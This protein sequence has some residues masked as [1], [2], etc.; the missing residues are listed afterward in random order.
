[1]NDTHLELE[2]LIAEATG[3]PVDDRTREHLARCEH[4]RLEVNRW[5]LVADGVL[6]L[7]AA[8]P[9]VAPPARPRH[10]RLRVLAGP[11]RPAMLAVGSVAAAFVLLVAIGAAAGLVHVSLGGGSG[12]GTE[13]TLTAVSG[14]STPV[15]MAS[16]TVERV[17][18]TSVVITTASGQPVT[19]T[20][21]AST[22][23]IVAGA[24]LSDITDGASVMVLGPTS[25]GTVAAVSVE[26][27]PVPGSKVT[28][29]S[30]W[31]AVQ[32]TVTDA[33]T[34]DFTVVTSGGTR[35]AVTTSGDTFVV[36]M[37]ASLSQLHPGIPTAA[38]GTAGPD[39][40]LAAQGIVQETPGSMQVHTSTKIRGCPST[41]LDDALAAALKSGS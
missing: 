9:E 30:G 41:T 2:D 27:G 4:C 6:D 13:T 39:N 37:K 14:C 35:V 28:P 26:V 8:T 1:M 31:T 36:V 15:E 16:G 21:T 7:A 5:N 11:R 10:T 19:V 3:Q 38:V 34:A 40:T 12:S 22:R 23:V 24:L 20:T 29:P 18:G 17:T 32:G 25:G 33:S